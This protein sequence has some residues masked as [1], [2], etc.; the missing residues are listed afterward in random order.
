MKK[1]AISEIKIPNHREYKTLPGK[2]WA[3]RL[4]PKNGINSSYTPIAKP[5]LVKP[6]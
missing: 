5:S 2:K 3:R 1:C 4:T 6:R